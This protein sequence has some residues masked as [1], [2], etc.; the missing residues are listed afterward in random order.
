MRNHLAICPYLS[1][2]RT[3]CQFR[4]I[5]GGAVLFL[6]G[7]PRGF[8]ASGEDLGAHVA[9]GLGPLV[10]LPGQ[11]RADEPDDG[12][13]AGEDAHD[14]GAAPDSLKNPS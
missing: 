10:A 7:F 2:N 12:V 3:N 11:D 6:A 8:P 1:G 13:T 4:N 9:A 14:V 5:L